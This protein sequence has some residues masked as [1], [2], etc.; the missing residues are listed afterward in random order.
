MTF[1]FL[2]AIFMSVCLIVTLF[3]LKPDTLKPSKLYFS[4]I[5]FTVIVWISFLTGFFTIFSDEFSLI[6]WNSCWIGLLIVGGF[7]FIY[8]CKNSLVFACTALLT[9][10]ING[11]FYLLAKFIAS[12]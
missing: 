12:M 6:L 11:G 3:A 9:S 10:L 4:F 8:E 5:I 7:T 2:L 1:I